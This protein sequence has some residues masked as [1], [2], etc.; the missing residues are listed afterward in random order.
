MSHQS[1]SGNTEGVLNRILSFFRT[2]MISNALSTLSLPS[3]KNNLYEQQLSE[4]H[5]RFISCC[6]YC[7]ILSQLCFSLPDCALW[8]LFDERHRRG[9]VPLDVDVFATEQNRSQRRCGW[10]WFFQ[11]MRPYPSV[12][13]LK[14]VRAL[15]RDDGI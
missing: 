2:T 11:C 5:M 4:Q 13:L 9:V 10:V 1:I 3:I 12:T 15:R 14:A 8:S 7:F 6:A